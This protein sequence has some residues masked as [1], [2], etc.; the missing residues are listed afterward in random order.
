MLKMAEL[1]HMVHHPSLD[2]LLTE[3]FFFGGGL[4]YFKNKNKLSALM[5]F[6][7]K[8]YGAAGAD[9]IQRNLG[10]QTGAALD[11]LIAGSKVRDPS[12]LFKDMNFFI[13]N[14]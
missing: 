6:A 4:A 7:N 12:K 8:G 10:L 11:T 9:I 13:S 1:L 3:E 14:S 2:L 5:C